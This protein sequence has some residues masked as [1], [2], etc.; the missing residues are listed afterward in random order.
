MT[1]FFKQHPSSSTPGGFSL[2][3]TLVATSI[4]L[5]VVVGPLAISSRTAKS[6]TFATEQ[7]TA[8]LLAQEGLELAEKARGDSILQQTLTVHQLMVG[9]RLQIRRSV[10]FQSVLIK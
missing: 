1:Y 9:M 4:L 8:Y 3:E 5:L 6:S 10:F 7:L 2:V